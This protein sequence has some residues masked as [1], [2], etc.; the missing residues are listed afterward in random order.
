MQPKSFLDIVNAALIDINE[1]PLTSSNFAN[2]RG[3]Q[4]FVKEVVNRSYLDIVNSSEGWS[5]LGEASEDPER[6]PGNVSK[7][8]EEGIQ[9]YWL[10][11]GST[12]Y[13]GDSPDYSSVDWDTF[14][15][16][17]MGVSDPEQEGN[18]VVA[19]K[20]I[21]YNQW[22]DDYREAD[23]P[24]ESVGVPRFVIKSTCGRKFGLSPKPDK[25]YKVNFIA[26]NQPETFQLASDVIP[27]PLQFYPVLLN[28]IRY[29]MWMFR[30]NPQQAA[31]A[32]QDYE[33][34]LKKMIHKI[35]N[36]SYEDMRAV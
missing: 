24:E 30:D 13:Y 26:W 28:R 4:A 27:I 17:D 31:M 8:V 19:L 14:F 11:E 16:T 18:T 33:Q 21:S 23:R 7:E 35:V 32:L 15:L 6:C 9:W 12:G 36:P 3:L 2:A 10:K 1:V 25:M 29:Y 22:Q 20:H 34:G 5:W